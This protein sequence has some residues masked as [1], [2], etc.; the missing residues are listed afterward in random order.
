MLLIRLA[1]GGDSFQSISAR[2][3]ICPSGP[4]VSQ[5]SRLFVL[6]LTH[7]H[8]VPPALHFSVPLQHLSLSSSDVISLFAHALLSLYLSAF[9]LFSPHPSRNQTHIQSVNW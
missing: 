7:T 4:P 9:F 1:V 2:P 6:F 8:F 5:P 3:I